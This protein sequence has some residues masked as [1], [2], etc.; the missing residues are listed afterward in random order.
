MQCDDRPMPWIQARERP[1]HEVA[2]GERAGDVRPARKIDRRELDLDD[3]TSSPAQEVEAGVDGQPV[4]PTV[5]AV[6]V[7]ESRQIAPGPDQC[8]LDRV[9]REFGVP[10]D[11]SSRRV[12]P[13]KTQV[14]KI[15]EGVM[16]A[17]LR[18]LDSVPLVHVRLDPRHD[19]CGRARRVRRRRRQKGSAREATPGR[20]QVSS[21]ASGHAQ[22]VGITWSGAPPSLALHGSSA[23]RC[24]LGTVSAGQAKVRYPPVTASM[25]IG[26]LV[27]A[28]SS[29]YTVAATDM[30]VDPS[31]E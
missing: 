10:E 11:E 27:S 26:S 17:P 16:I 24:Q 13:R 28:V 23:S 19:S 4:E 14:D 1:I 7:P 25:A 8:L 22:R 5:E 2:V 15:G 20:Q 30:I 6:R 31:G 9:T 3:P 21:R 29:S 12:Q 18:P